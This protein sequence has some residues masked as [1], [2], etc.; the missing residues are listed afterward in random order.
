MVVIK[1]SGKFLCVSVCVCVCVCLGLLHGRPL[2]ER[3]HNEQ[4]HVNPYF[5]RMSLNV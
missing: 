5:T 3:L 2:S 4:I 1:G